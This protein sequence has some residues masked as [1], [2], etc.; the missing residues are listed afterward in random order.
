MECCHYSANVLIRTFISNQQSHLLTWPSPV[1]FACQL[2]GCGKK[3]SER[4]N[5]GFLLISATAVA[6]ALFCLSRGVSASSGGSSLW[7]IKSS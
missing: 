5:D 1:Y 7:F 3:F 6:A 4:N 2:P